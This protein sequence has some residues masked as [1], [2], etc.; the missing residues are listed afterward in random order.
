MQ[1][2]V[3]IVGLLV[4]TGALVWAQAE[5]VVAEG[6]E[7]TLVGDEFVFTEGPA[8]EADGNVVFSDVRT[9]RRYRWTPES[10]EATL[11]AEDTGGANG[12]YFGPNGHLVVCEG[13]RGRM[14]SIAPDGEVTVLADTYAGARFNR[15]N[16]VWVAPDGGVYFTDPNYGRGE[17]SQDGEHVYYIPPD[18]GEV[19]R[20]IDWMERPNGLIG[21]PDGSTLYI[22]DAGAG[23]TWSFPRAEDGTLGERCLFV[24]KGADGM[25][26]DAERNVYLSTD[27]IVSFTPEGEQ[28]ERIELPV[29]PTNMCFAGPE[30]RT[31]L[32]TARNS[33][34][35]VQMRVQGATR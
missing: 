11:V 17:L 20:I 31:L 14:T 9:S 30:L 34:F 4:A 12:M 6:A 27:A 2:A 5:R 23:Q 16:D 1:T 15:P 3:T 21:T 32:I 13:D 19:V 26:I 7:L 8:R 10:G 28:I 22:T 18:G 35:T 33:V 29:R 25:T 24:E